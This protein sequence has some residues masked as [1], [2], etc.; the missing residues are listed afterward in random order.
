MRK[1]MDARKII[2]ITGIHGMLDNKEVNAV[3]RSLVV[4]TKCLQDKCGGPTSPNPSFN[5]HL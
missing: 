5:D 1:E 3:E 4:G 2:L